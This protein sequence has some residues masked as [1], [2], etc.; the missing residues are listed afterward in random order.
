MT[1]RRLLQDVAAENRLAERLINYPAIAKYDQPGDKEGGNLAHAFSDL[2][3]AFL[4]FLEDQLPKLTESDLDEAAIYDLLLD[5]GEELRQ[6]LY[7]IQ[8]TRF[9]A[10]LNY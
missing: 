7:Q 8:H 2:E 5:I 6:I 4:T 10:Y 9:Y 1:A 3:E